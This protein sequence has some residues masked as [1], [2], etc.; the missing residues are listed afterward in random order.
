MSFEVGL[1]AD[2]RL[3]DGAPE[4]RVALLD[5]QGVPWRF[6]AQREA[7]ISASAIAGL[8][9]LIVN[10]PRV[11]ASTLDCPDP[12]L[13]IARLGAGYDSIDV[14][15]CTQR[16]VMVSTAPDGVRR[17]MA[18]GAMALLLALAHRLP[19]KLVRAR[20]G[21]WDRDQVGSGLG[22]RVLGIV[23]YGSIGTEISALARPFG[24][25]VIAHTRS[26]RPQPD[27]EFVD[28]MTLMRAADYVVATLPATPDT[29]GLLSAE[30]FAAM[31]QDAYFVNIGRGQTV[32][33][34]ALTAALAEGRLAGAALDV[35]ATEP[36]APDDPL[37][38]LGNVLVTPHTIGL[39]REMLDDVGDSASRSVL[40]VAEH[41]VPETLINPDV[42][43]HPRL[44][45]RFVH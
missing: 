1:T 2:Q 33:Q 32:D 7:T 44:H 36:L 43:S 21:R 22:G 35:F 18:A 11:T 12:P 38:R 10:G 6:L 28:L 25:R 40:A 39:T 17:P 4:Y 14:E 20:A 31:K 23:G 19:E 30:C 5:R 24:M 15:A 26:P 9:A 45:G 41:R 3:Q 27:V 34:A 29:R 8:G 16:G 13:L 42:L 37:T